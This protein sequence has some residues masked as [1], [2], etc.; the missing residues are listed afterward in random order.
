MEAAFASFQDIPATEIK[1]K[2]NL[3]LK[4]KYIW[5][6]ISI[7]PDA[8]YRKWHF[9]TNTLNDCDLFLLYVYVTQVE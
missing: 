6:E 8:L 5:K 4:K 3:K 9:C 7:F 1:K 2:I